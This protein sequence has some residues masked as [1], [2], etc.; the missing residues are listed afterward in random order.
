M[1]ELELYVDSLDPSLSNEEKV[2]LVQEWK[3]ANRWNEQEV[4]VSEQVELEEVDLG[5]VK[6]KDGVAGADVPSEIAAPKDTDSQLENI[7]SELV[8]PEDELLKINEKVNSIDLNTSVQ[9]KRTGG[10]FSQSF[11]VDIIPYEEQRIQA[12]KTLEEQGLELNEQAIQ[13]QMRELIR[14]REED[15]YKAREHDKNAPGF[16][17]L[18][19]VKKIASTAG[20]IFSGSL[21]GESGL[22]KIIARTFYGEELDAIEKQYAKDSTEEAK[23]VNNLID[24]SYFG[25]VKDVGSKI[26]SPQYSQ[27]KE[28]FENLSGED[29]DK[30]ALDIADKTDA[31]VEDL[32]KDIFKYKMGVTESFSDAIEQ[33][34]F[35]GYIRALTQATKEA[36][37]S[38]TYMAVAAV[39]GGL[40]IIG[41]S[42][43]AGG[44][45]KEN[46]EGSKAYN[47]LINLKIT[48]PDYQSK[49]QE[50]EEKIRN[51]QISLQ[52]LAHHT[53]VG[54]TNSVFERWSGG[55]ARNFFNTFKNQP[56]EVFEKNLK[57]YVL[58]FVKAIGG[59]GLTEATQTA[60]EKAS[61]VGIQGK[62]V[63]FQEAMQEIYDA[64][65][66]GTVSAVGPSGTSN[67]INILRTSINNKKEKSLVK[68]AGVSNAVELFE[69]DIKPQGLDF[70]SIPNGSVRINAEL[71]LQVSNGQKTT[72]EANAVKNRYREVQGAVNQLKPLDIS[73]QNQPV[74]VD[75]MIEQ[76]NLQQKIKEVDN[77]SLTKA[78]SA[79]LKEIDAELNSLVTQDRTLKNIKG[80]EAFTEG[81]EG[82][83][84]EI[85]KGTEDLIS[86]VEAIEAN[87]GEVVGLARD[88]KGNILPA[89]DQNYGFI[90]RMGDGTTQ[91][92]LNEVSALKDN[93]ATTC[94]LYT[95]P[96]PRD[97]QKSR[98]P[99]SA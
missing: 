48:D 18:D 56:I 67:S 60:I 72:E 83:G 86:S 96:S 45:F 19:T 3:K 28:I 53:V 55:L 78:E 21:R 24:D 36:A 47:E 35:S 42:T 30:L 73:I 2:R 57:Q 62:E 95:S 26:L 46:S 77:S 32:D 90:S 34:D 63:D 50:L 59:E 25:V 23:A 74:M 69:G 12:K 7:F 14:Q 43:A 38:A 37:G 31:Y 5:T 17:T 39:P 16:F 91:I 64:A 40:G 66:I 92:I 85:I 99:S 88:E 51:G 1:N 98:M 52:N 6:K 70:T 71:D 20:N 27:A 81:L 68:E 84:L 80:A 10:K 61:N 11:D 76:K 93:V 33:G 75:L 22:N 89:E 49:K 65:I 54:V 29:V 94:L 79:R 15:R 58:D 41:V 13:N 87:G 44:E 9:T 82:V 97:R 8:V 4:E